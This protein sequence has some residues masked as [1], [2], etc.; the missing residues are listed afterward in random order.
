[1]LKA[2]RA[3]RLFKDAMMFFRYTAISDDKTCEQCNQYDGGLM[4]RE[5][6]WNTFPHLEKITDL[7]YYPHVHPNCRCI[8]TMEEEEE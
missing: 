6:M 3:V 5:E 8:L 2:V 7:L 1:M 4:T